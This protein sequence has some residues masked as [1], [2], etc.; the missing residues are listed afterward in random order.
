[1]EALDHCLSLIRSSVK[2]STQAFLNVQTPTRAAFLADFCTLFN[3][4]NMAT[5]H[6]R[7]LWQEFVCSQ[8][9]GCQLPLAN[10]FGIFNQTHPSS[11]HP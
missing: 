9:N 6:K 8:L 3:D 7:P 4:N 5:A 11:I 2:E 10:L 1:L